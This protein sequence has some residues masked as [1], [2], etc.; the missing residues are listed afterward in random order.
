[1]RTKVFNSPALR[2]SVFR[3]GDGSLTWKGT[4]NGAAI[5]AA[6]PVDDECVILLDPDAS[7][8]H[9]FKNLLRIACDGHPRWFAEL[10]TS[11][12]VFLA[13]RPEGDDL[14]ANT[15]SGFKVRI[16]PGS[17]RCLEQEFVK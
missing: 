13:V 14:A 3:A 6:V 7:K 2:L 9:V 12:D 16:D 8:E 15:W 17:G 5:K 10:P 1:M 4:Y 11:P